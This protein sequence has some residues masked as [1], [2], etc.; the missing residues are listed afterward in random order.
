MTRN[1]T[2]QSRLATAPF[3]DEAADVVLRSSDG[4]DFRVYKVLLSLVSSFFRDMLALPHVGQRASDAG[5]H[6]DCGGRPII[7]VEEDANGVEKLLRWCDPR[8]TP[9]TLE[10]WEDVQSTTQLSIKYDAPTIYRRVSECLRHSS[11]VHQYPI[12]VY[13][14]AVRANN[15]QLAR[16]AAREASCLGIAT[17][18]A[19]SELAYIPASEFQRLLRYHLARS[20]RAVEI[21]EKWAKSGAW[22]PRFWIH[23]GHSSVGGVHLCRGEW[24]REYIQKM[25]AHVEKYPKGSAVQEPG[26]LLVSSSHDNWWCPNCDGR[27]EAHTA[28]F[29]IDLA[30]E[31]DKELDKVS[32]DTRLENGYILTFSLTCIG[33]TEF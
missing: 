23:N 24:W 31:L 22:A 5:D 9:P 12:Q 2:T 4:V 8:C 25:R 33:R 28:R 30:K 27:A 21:V 3:D 19:C 32:S 13:V 18:A 20:A 6:A 14:V 15:I 29:I 26:F 11:F 1:E 10:S 17:W 7:D 16:A